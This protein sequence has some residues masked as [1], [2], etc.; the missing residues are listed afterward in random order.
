MN[1]FLLYCKEH[2]SQVANENPSFSNSDVTS[3]LGENWRN[4][5]PKLKL[6]Y[7]YRAKKLREEYRKKTPIIIPDKN[8]SEFDKMKSPFKKQRVQPVKKREDEIVQSFLQQYDHILEQ[9]TRQYSSYVQYGYYPMVHYE[10][11]FSC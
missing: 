6:I 7:T 9:D 2:R 4:L 3:Q 10:N 8:V 11:S 5:D 1:S